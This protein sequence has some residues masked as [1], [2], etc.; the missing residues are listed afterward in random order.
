MQVLATQLPE[1][2]NVLEMFGVGPSLGTQRITEIGD[3]RRLY[4]K[5]A[6]VAYAGSVMLLRTTPAI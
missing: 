2:L 5:K 1:Y 4:S 3:V 6:L